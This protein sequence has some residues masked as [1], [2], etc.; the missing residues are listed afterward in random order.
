MSKAKMQAAKEL[1][2][3]KQYDEARTILKTV[4]HPTA[5]QWEK[6]LSDLQVPPKKPSNARWVLIGLVITGLLIVA[7]AVS[8]SNSQNTT[9]GLRDILD[10]DENYYL[11]RVFET[12]TAEAFI[13]P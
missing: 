2:Q 6:R 3:A 10:H 9:A 13:S 11:T 1:I 12:R 5:R 8:W 7:L 4:D